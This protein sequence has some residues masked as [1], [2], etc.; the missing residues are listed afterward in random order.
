MTTDIVS[1]SAPTV[2]AFLLAL[3]RVGGF[4][5]AAPALSHRSVPISVRI[6][7]SLAIAWAIHP[8]ILSQMPVESSHLVE[9][10]VLGAGEVLVGVIIGFVFALLFS[11]LQAAGELVGLQVGFGLANVYDYTAERQV[12]V[13][14]Q[15]ELVL[16]ML[17]FFAIDGHHLMLRAFFDSYR[18]VGPAALSLTGTGLDLLVRTSAVLFVIAIKA[19]A[20]VLAAV[21]L[22]EIAL[23]IT[24]R[25]VPQMNVFVIG[26][27][28]KIGVGLFMLAGALPLFGAVFGNLLL[29]LSGSLDQVL[30]ALGAA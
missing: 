13:L 12:G 9:F 5:A 6:G 3:L 14:G 20:P 24:A 27:P 10:L 28:L 18:I 15:L 25:T 11:G 7:L 19:A 8:R 30:V 16:G 17:L 2:Q 23:G 29:H 21:F 26:F 22:T 4:I 1:I